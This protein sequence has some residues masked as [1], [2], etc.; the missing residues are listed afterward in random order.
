MVRDQIFGW[1]GNIGMAPPPLGHS[2]DAWWDGML[3]G[4]PKEKG[5]E[6]SGAFI[7]SMWGGLEGAK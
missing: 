5:S 6:A 4:I 3:A 7:Y 1:K 2:I